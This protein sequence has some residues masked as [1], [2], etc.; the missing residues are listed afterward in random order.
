MK[1][2]ANI[3]FKKLH[4]S[5]QTQALQPTIIHIKICTPIAPFVY[6][7]NVHCIAE[8][9]LVQFNFILITF[10][11]CQRLSTKACMLMPLTQFT[12]KTINDAI[13][14]SH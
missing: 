6:H 3:I 11:S 14:A 8:R 7:S 13:K 1:L 12:T 4:A 2:K 5:H 10:S 9:K